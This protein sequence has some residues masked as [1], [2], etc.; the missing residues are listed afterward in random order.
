MKTLLIA[1]LLAAPVAAA[2][3]LAER[4]RAEFLFSWQAYQKYAW[5][6]DELRPLS[7]TPRDW[8]GESLLMTPV[9]SLDTLILMGFKDEA[10]KARALIVERLS[11]DKDISVQNFEVTIRLLGG[12][13]SAYELT[14]DQH[15]LQLAD[16]L[17]TRLLPV[18][19]SPTGMPY[20]FVNLRTGKTSG[21]KSNPAEIGTLILEF[22]TLSK[23]TNKPVYF[24]KA[25]NA[26][27]QLYKRRSKIGLVGEEIDVET[28]QWTNPSSHVGG[29]IDSY[30]EY[31]LKCAKLFGDK[32]CQSMWESSIRAVN[33]Y[34]ADGAWYGEA[35]M[36]SGKRTATQFGSLHAFLPAVLAL[37]GDVRRARRLE[38]SAYKM[39]QLYG[40]EPEVI[41][42]KT[43][44]VVYPE[45]P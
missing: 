23:L 1:I 6:H 22:G 43:M 8:Y 21:P 17:G 2:D 12:L 18:F 11:F 34:L 30:Y 38:A 10:D 14:G 25:K 33:K 16:D 7:K 19:N 39:W 4:V 9:D 31:L 40:V 20:R 3:D 24:D 44:K 35:D 32:D 29:G 37:G 27:V 15:L 13:L 42:Y 26:I 5:G 41:D 45:Y 36:N 28:G